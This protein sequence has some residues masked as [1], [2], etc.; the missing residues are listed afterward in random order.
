[1][2]N[3]ISKLINEDIRVKKAVIKTQSNAIASLAKMMIATL[4][5]GNKILIIG[6]A[7]IN[8][9]TNNEGK[10]KR[11]VEIDAS[12]VTLLDD[13]MSIKLPAS[14]GKSE[15]AEQ[16]QTF[17]KSNSETEQVSNFDE[18][19]SNTEEIPF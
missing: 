1:M 14:A 19:V 11:E 5:A 6:R 12:T 3:K 16:T 15:K 4:K 7:H 17:K 10:K 9:Y 13:V 8:A 18:L 2:I